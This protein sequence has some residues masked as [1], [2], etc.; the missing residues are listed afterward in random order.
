M[1]PMTLVYYAGICG[2]LSLAGPRLGGRW[3]RF[4]IGVLVGLG[5]AVALPAIRA[6]LG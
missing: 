6:A 3:A 4:G 2:L 1:D 5:A